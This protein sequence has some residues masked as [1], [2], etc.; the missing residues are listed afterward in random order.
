MLRIISPERICDV[1]VSEFFIVIKKK[2]IEGDGKI[3]WGLGFLELCLM[4][5]VVSRSN[6]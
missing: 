3:F 4:S 2:Y 6:R 1:F 5:W